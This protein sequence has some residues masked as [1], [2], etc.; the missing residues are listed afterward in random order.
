MPGEV[1]ARFTKWKEVGQKFKFVW[2]IN[3]II[4]S[5]WG[6]KAKMVYVFRGLDRIAA[7]AAAAPVRIRE[8]RV[9]LN[10]HKSF[11][12]GRQILLEM[13]TAGLAMG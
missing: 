5:F 2:R 1:L 8:G 12:G 3:Q 4:V 13:K 9:K 7:S 11:T 10:E 6:Q